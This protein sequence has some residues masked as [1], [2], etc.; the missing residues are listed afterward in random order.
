MLPARPSDP[1]DLADSSDSTDAS[2]FPSGVRAGPHTYRFG[3]L[4]ALEALDDD[5][6]EAESSNGISNASNA[7]CCTATPEFPLFREITRWCAT[8]LK[9]APMCHH[10]IQT[11]SSGDDLNG[12]WGGQA[13]GAEVRIAPQARSLRRLGS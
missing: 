12:S 4:D 7:T 8:C 13:Q 11:S 2:D 5:S 6:K 1:T 3:R 10:S 9:S